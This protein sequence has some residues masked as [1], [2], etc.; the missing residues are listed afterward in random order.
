MVAAQEAHNHAVEHEAAHVVDH[1]EDH[2]ED[3]EVARVADREADHEVDLEDPPDVVLGAVLDAGGADLVGKMLDSRA[4]LAPQ[5]VP[6]VVLEVDLHAQVAVLL[7]H[8]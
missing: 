5:E 1:E 4:A 8:P 3:R 2:G 7:D 6:A